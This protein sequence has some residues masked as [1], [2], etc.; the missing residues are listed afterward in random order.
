MISWQTLSRPISFWRISNGLKNKIPTSFLFLFFGKFYKIK[1]NF[2]RFSSFL[3]SFI[4]PT[5][6]F[7]QFFIASSQCTSLLSITLFLIPSRSQPL[8]ASWTTIT[9]TIPTTITIWILFEQSKALTMI[10]KTWPPLIR[11]RIMVRPA[12]TTISTRSL[13][14]FLITPIQRFSYVLFKWGCCFVY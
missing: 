1:V 3:S 8:K 14:V 12:L 10:T 4:L 7:L 6:T 11:L 5:T 9:T 13:R 2:L